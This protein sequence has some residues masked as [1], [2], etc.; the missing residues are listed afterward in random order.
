[1]RPYYKVF[2]WIMLVASVYF[3]FPDI[4]DRRITAIVLDVVCAVVTSRVLWLDYKER[5]L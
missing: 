3:L 4:H 2:Y 1:M 5:K